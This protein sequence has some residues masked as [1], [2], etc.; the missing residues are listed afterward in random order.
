MQRCNAM[1]DK[2]PVDFHHT[3]TPDSALHISPLVHRRVAI[4]FST[5]VAELRHPHPIPQPLNASC[6]ELP[7]AEPAHPQRAPGAR[8]VLS[9]IICV[10]D[11]AFHRSVLVPARQEAV[12]LA[13]ASELRDVE[14]TGVGEAG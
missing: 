6:L 10:A 11:G 5:R 3:S 9:L 4:G 7:S 13:E 12:V 2:L 1:N 8:V 14:W